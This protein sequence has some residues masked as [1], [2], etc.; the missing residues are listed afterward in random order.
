MCWDFRLARLGVGSQVSQTH[1]DRHT[2]V[3]HQT[4]GDNHAERRSSAVVADR[5]PEYRGTVVIGSRWVQFG[6]FVCLNL[7]L[8]TPL[9]L[10]V[11]SLFYS[12]RFGR[13]RLLLSGFG[14]K[15]SNRDLLPCFSS[16]VTG[17]VCKGVRALRHYG[18]DARQKNG[19]PGSAEL[20]NAANLDPVGARHDARGYAR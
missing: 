1:Q 13:L 3:L 6:N 15:L 5:E 10:S 17:F 11:D 4:S 16:E 12:Q 20:G 19:R 8:R 9:Q 2:D 18:G 7:D 14:S